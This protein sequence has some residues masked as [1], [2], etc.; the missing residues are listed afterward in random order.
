VRATC[1][2]LPCVAVPHQ[3]VSRNSET[4]RTLLRLHLNQ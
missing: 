4:L 1:V 3:R 2:L